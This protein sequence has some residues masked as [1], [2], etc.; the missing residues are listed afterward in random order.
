M[1]R[2]QAVRWRR[3]TWDLNESQSQVCVPP[4]GTWTGSGVKQSPLP[5]FLVL[6]APRARP[7][8]LPAGALENDANEV[9][10]DQPVRTVNAGEDDDFADDEESEP[11]KIVARI[12]F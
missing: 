4:Q 11:V 7:A 12:D 6:S 2:R 8:T 10:V 1:R 9:P 5:V 3:R